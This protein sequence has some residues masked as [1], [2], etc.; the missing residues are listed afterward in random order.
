[1]Q[2]VLATEHLLRSDPS[3]QVLVQF[4]LDVCIMTPERSVEEIMEK[5]KTIQPTGVVAE[6]NDR[7]ALIAD[8]SSRSAHI[9][10]GAF[11]LQRWAASMLL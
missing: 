3:V 7:C 5:A 4:D 8:V 10:A 1:M 2:R 11:I 9:N 6:G